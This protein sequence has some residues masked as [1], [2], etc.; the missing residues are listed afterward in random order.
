MRRRLFTLLSALSLLLCMASV[1]LWVRSYWITDRCRLPGESPPRHAAWSHWGQVGIDNAPE[2]AD[3]RKRWQDHI[4]A[5][6]DLSIDESAD[7]V[8][9]R[10]AHGPVPKIPAGQ[11]H[12]MPHAAIAGLFALAPVLWSLPR[13]RRRGN[14]RRLSGLCMVCGYDTRATPNRCPECGTAP[15]TRPTSN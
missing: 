13:F 12:A 1:V 11:T 9:K 2:V 6:L 8:R 4:F 14:Q 15:G 10:R 7:T 5:E 3:A